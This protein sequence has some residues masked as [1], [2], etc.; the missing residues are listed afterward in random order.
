MKN[1]YS[2]I[3]DREQTCV[4][5]FLLSP[6]GAVAQK[7]K[8]DN[9]NDND[10][11]IP[12]KSNALDKSSSIR[13]AATE[14]RLS[15]I[16]KWPGGKEKELKYIM[17]LV[18]QPIRNYYEPFVG[19]GSV[20]AAMHAERYYINDKSDELVALYENIAKGDKGFFELCDTVDCAWRTIHDFFESNE[21]LVET[22]YNYKSQK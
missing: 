17:P 9:D 11:I 7:I 3:Q 22:Y 16:L 21:E 20:F 18:P 5:D 8:A 10:K 14:M 4:S 1:V 12:N 6:Y 2:D 15:P 19:G 13:I